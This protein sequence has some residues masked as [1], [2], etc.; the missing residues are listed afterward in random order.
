MPELGPSLGPRLRLRSA[1]G[2]SPPSIAEEP[3]IASSSGSRPRLP[4]SLALP[5]T[6]C[7]SRSRRASTSLPRT[8]LLGLSTSC[9]TRLSSGRRRSCC[10]SPEP[11]WR[12]RL[13]DRLPVPIP[14]CQVKVDRG[15]QPPFFRPVAS[16]H[17]AQ[18]RFRLVRN[19]RSGQHEISGRG[20]GRRCQRIGRIGQSG[21]DAK[22]C[23]SSTH[24]ASRRPNAVPESGPT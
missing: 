10:R 9:F 16:L 21:V 15:R 14:L 18:R 24:C 17:K 23:L 20:I 6:Y 13:S 4:L 3:Q 22:G 8:A 1:Q 7:H 12:F 11:G 2:C 19:A 5:S